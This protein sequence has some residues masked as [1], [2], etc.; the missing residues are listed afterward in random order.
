MKSLLIKA[1][2]TIIKALV[3]AFNYEKV[4]DLVKDM[5]RTDLIGVEKRH[6]VLLE[7]QNIAFVVGMS[8]LNLA[9]EA[10][11]VKVKAIK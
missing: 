8:L 5:E 7:C 1:L 11:V 6:R 2:E 9:I 10:A 4:L 3:G